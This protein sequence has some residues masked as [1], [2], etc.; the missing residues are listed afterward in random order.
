MTTKISIDNRL[1]FAYDFARHWRVGRS[2]FLIGYRHLFG[3]LLVVAIVLSQGTFSPW[4][5]ADTF[6]GRGSHAAWQAANQTYNEGNRLS[7]AGKYMDAVPKYKTAIQLYPYD[8]SYFHNLAYAYEKAGQLPLAEAAY[9]EALKLNPKAW[10]SWNGLKNV[11]YKEGK[12]QDSRQACLKAL[13]CGPP[14]QN[15]ASIQRALARLEQELKAR[16][17][18]RRLTP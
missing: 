9:K 6:P 3:I 5:H 10:D 12:Y 17:L 13:E 15:R 18:S 14:D 8:Q 16:P 1:E 2:S 4:A 11:F 7:D